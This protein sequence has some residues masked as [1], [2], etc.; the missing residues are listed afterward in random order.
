LFPRAAKI[1]C[2]ER[3]IPCAATNFCGGAGR[4]ANTNVATISNAAGSQGLAKAVDARKA[5]VTIKAAQG[6]ITGTAEFKVTE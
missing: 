4:R 6:T 5:P 3:L 1:A 2:S